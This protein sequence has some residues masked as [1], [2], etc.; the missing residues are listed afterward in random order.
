MKKSGAFYSYGD[1][2]L[3]QG[4]ENSKEFLT[5]HSEI[6]DFLEARIRGFE[7]DK[8]E[9]AN[10]VRDARAAASSNGAKP[11]PVSP[12]GLA[13]GTEEPEESEDKD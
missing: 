9:A 13:A 2:R 8:Q 12:E 5:Q 6:A 7:R 10:E 3:G 4:R 11:A 1:T